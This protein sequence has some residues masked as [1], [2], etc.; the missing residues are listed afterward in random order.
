MPVIVL[1][2][3]D[4]NIIANMFVT[5]SKRSLLR[6]RLRDVLTK[7]LQTFSQTIQ[8]QPTSLAWTLCLYI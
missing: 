2:N 4:A 1:L 6:W 3:V 8:Q 5:S 7:S